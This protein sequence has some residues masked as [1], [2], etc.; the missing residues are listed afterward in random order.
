L[1]FICF[2]AVLEISLDSQVRIDSFTIKSFDSTITQS[3][4]I[5]SPVSNNI[6]SH[7]TNSFEFIWISFPSLITVEKDSNIFLSA[8]TAFSALYS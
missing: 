4:G 3:A 7:G 5:F 1:V 2:I 8:S 6:I